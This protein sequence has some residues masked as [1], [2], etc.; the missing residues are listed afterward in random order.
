M[1]PSARKERKKTRQILFE[2]IAEFLASARKA[3]G[4]GQSE[5]A[6]KA[7]VDVNTVSKIENAQGNPTIE[8]VSKIARALDLEMMIRFDTQAREVR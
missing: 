6:K 2:R 7:K 3:R 8:S 5:L 4:W 1:T